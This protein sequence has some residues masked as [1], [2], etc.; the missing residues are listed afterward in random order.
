LR[1]ESPF[2]LHWFKNR[3]PPSPTLQAGFHLEC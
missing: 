3:L 2:I 1:V